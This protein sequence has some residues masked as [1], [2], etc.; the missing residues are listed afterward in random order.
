MTK[1]AAQ[2]RFCLLTYPRTGSNLFVKILNLD[3]QP[4]LASCKDGGYFFAPLNHLRYDMGFAGAHVQEMTTDQ[5]AAEAACMKKCFQALT[6]YIQ[7]A[8]NEDQGIF[9]KEHTHI[10]TN[11][12]AKTRFIFGVENTRKSALPSH[13]GE[14]EM[15]QKTT[16]GQS[17]HNETLLPDDFLNTLKPTFLIRHPALAFPSYYRAARRA[18]G[19]LYLRSEQGQRVC[20]NIMTLRWSRKLYDFYS[21]NFNVTKVS[22]KEEITWPLVLEADDIMI[23]PAVMIRFCE[24]L[25]LDV[26]QL[27]FEWDKDEQKRRPGIM[28]FRSTID[29]STGIDT[30]KASGGIINLDG[31]AREWRE[32]FGDDAGRMI[33][34]CVR[35]AMNDYEYLSENK[36]RA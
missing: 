14:T 10:L 29:G 6:E 25:G 1:S 28:A 35:E 34:V 3:N 15:A 5:R 2:C 23:K 33:E 27:R 9:F 13:L 16:N 22:A 17:P 31:C 11:P 30:S 8:E 24:I 19:D 18:D 12:V 20:R 36:L 4:N 7:G 26:A 32:E 21:Q